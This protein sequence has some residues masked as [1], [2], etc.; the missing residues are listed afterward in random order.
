MTKY[1]LAIAALIAFAATGV[2]VAQQPAQETACRPAV[3]LNRA[4]AADV[5]ALQAD[6]A[7]LD[8]AAQARKAKLAELV[9]KAGGAA[10]AAP[11][12]ISSVASAPANPTLNF[13][14]PGAANSIQ[15][16]YLPLF[17]ARG[18]VPSFHLNRKL[19]GADQY[20]FSAQR[21]YI[22][23]VSLPVL[24]DATA[25][26]RTNVHGQPE[27]EKAYQALL[28]QID[29]GC[30]PIATLTESPWSEPAPTT[31]VVYPVR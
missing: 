24:P 31:G 22:M 1:F 16:R 3:S 27:A 28:S 10:A 14:A 2:G 4:T 21:T 13:P 6:I 11:P 15:L 17:E 5:A 30:A 9:G 29:A 12:P 7:C 18:F 26:R 23:Y 19:D 25:D 20:S 8:Q